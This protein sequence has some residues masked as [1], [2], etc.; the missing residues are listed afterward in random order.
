[1]TKS[2]AVTC[3]CGGSVLFLAQGCMFVALLLLT[4]IILEE[5]SGRSHALGRG[6]RVESK[7]R[8]IDT[9]VLRRPCEHPRSRNGLQVTH[10][11]KIAFGPKRHSRSCEGPDGEKP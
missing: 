1:M 9:Q 11:S 6:E 10:I 7:P 2:R 8:H 5:T 4:T 3:D